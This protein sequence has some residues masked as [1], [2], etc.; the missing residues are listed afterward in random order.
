M[1]RLQPGDAAGTK[2]AEVGAA[3]THEA[4]SPGMDDGEERDDFGDLMAEIDLTFAAL[5][6]EALEA[7]ASPDTEESPERADADEPA[8]V[9]DSLGI[10]L[11]ELASCALLGRDAELRIAK[12]IEEGQ[13]RV[14]AEALVS[15]LGVRHLIRLGERLAAE[16]IRVRDVV[17]DVD[18]D[19]EGA[20]EQEADLREMLLQR[21]PEA[22]RLAS[23][24]TERRRCRESRSGRGRAPNEESRNA[25]AR[26]LA[27][28]EA[29]RLNHRQIEAVIE[30]M[31]GTLAAFDECVLPIGRYEKRFNRPLTEILQLCQSVARS[32]D[33]SRRVLS[34]LRIDAAEAA[35]IDA[36]IRAAA[37][38]LR[39]AER[40][41]GVTRKA[42]RATLDR[43][44]KAQRDM[45]CAR[46]RLIEANLRLVVS[47]ARRYSN[48]GLHL[49]DLV[50]EGNI[51]LMKAVDRFEHQRGFKFSTYAAWW[52]RQAMARAISDQVRTIRV[53]V[54]V[55]EL[56]GKVVRASRSM[57]Q[58]LGREP[59]NEELARWMDMPVERVHWIL[60]VVREPLSLDT[61]IGEDEDTRLGDMVEDERTL[62]PA[63][64]MI[65]AGLRE[66]TRNALAALTPR[67]RE[68][69]CLRFGIGE[70]RDLTL[71]EVGRRFDVTR[72]RVRQIEGKALRKLRHPTRSRLLRSVMEG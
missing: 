19:E 6:E 71:E 46:A 12:R 60:G 31:R 32:K 14:I 16:E 29:M 20:E 33:D 45:Q 36:E 40:K 42:L 43:V 21:I 37:R 34:T 55:I 10:Y 59:T 44:E 66:E 57:V 51:G 17:R 65:S 1:K 64:V 28:V 13:H 54:H 48:R 27:A 25:R 53:P 7:E 72:E 26:L 38:R 24:L 68:V 56:I 50:Q 5:H 3:R 15:P 63:E 52:I 11:R 35:V 67:E 41:A 18:E 69:L 58:T 47:I 61:P 49:L 4:A 23:D 70:E 30:E 9:S 8:R 22:V 2:P 62:D 39:T